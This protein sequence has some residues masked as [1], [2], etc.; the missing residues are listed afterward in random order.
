VYQLSSTP[1]DGNRDDD[2]FYS[3]YRPKRLS[4]EQILDALGQ[5]TGQME[6]F[7]GLPDGFKAQQLPD[8]RVPSKFLDMFGRPLRRVASC[9]CERV[10]E[11]N[12]GQ[13]LELL[14]SSMLDQRVTAD[15][16]LV[17][18]LLSQAM[19]DRTV[20]DEIYLGAVGRMPTMME[21]EALLAAMEPP[22]ASS[23]AGGDIDLQA[24]AASRREFFEDVLWALLNS[25]EFL[26]NH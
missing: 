1:T 15:G 14:N 4:A 20:L 10:A 16:S 18:R 11:P 12:L 9:E 19:D 13:A 6:K 8:T 21:A 26:F 23:D 7:E 2:R 3:F 17:N 24:R 5:V 25:K 22:S